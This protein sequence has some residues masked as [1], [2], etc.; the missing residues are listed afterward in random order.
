MSILFT[1]LNHG[2]NAEP[3]APEV[4]VSWDGV[5][6]VL[7]FLMN[8]FQFPEYSEDE[9]GKVT[10][11]ECSRYRLGT[12]NDEGWHRGQGRF[13]DVNH[14]WGEFYEVTGNLRLDRLPDDWEVRIHEP[15]DRR[16][17]LF[18]FRDEDFECD[19]RDWRFEVFK[20]ASVLP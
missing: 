6:L 4:S 12:L 8:P 11:L 17:F 20:P 10:F 1:Q 13:A 14:R 15:A 18:Y 9:I 5:D 7:R 16:H 19:A 3:N 2:W